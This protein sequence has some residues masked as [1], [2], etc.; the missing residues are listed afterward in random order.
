MT[1]S[2]DQIDALGKEIDPEERAVLL[3]LVQEGRAAEDRTALGVATALER[4]V[5]DVA[6]ALERLGRDGLASRSVHTERGDCWRPTL[7]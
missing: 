3:V 1:P 4:D 5:V 6:T 2:P 7:N